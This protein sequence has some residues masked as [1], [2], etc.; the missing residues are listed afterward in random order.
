MKR[1]YRSQYLVTSDSDHNVYQ[2]AFLAVDKDKIIDAGLWKNRPR[3]KSYKTIDYSNAVITPGLFNLHSHLAMTFLKGIVEDVDLNTWLFDYILPA[4]KKLVSKKFVELGTQLALTECLK[5]GTTYIADMYFHPEQVFSAFSKLGLRGTVGVSFF[6]HGGMDTKSLDESFE[7]ILSMNQKFKQNKLLDLAIAPHAPYTCSKQNLRKGV[8]IAKELG[9]PGMIHVAETRFEYDEIMAKHNQSPLQYVYECG[10][11]D[12]PYLLLAHMLHLNEHEDYQILQNTR[13]T[14]ILTPQCNA[15]LASGTPLAQQYKDNAIRFTMG[16]DGSASNNS[17][18]IF[19]ELNF[20]AKLL[21]LQT[22][23]L[24]GI[25]SR[26]LFDSVTIRA[27]E[28]VG[29][30]NELGS[31]EAGKQADFIVIPLDKAHLF[32]VNDIYSQLLY[33]IRGHDVRDVYIQ[34]KAVLKN[35]KVRGLDEAQ[36][37]QKCQRYWK[38]A[39]KAL[40]SS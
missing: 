15:K 13:A 37:F 34:G 29:K 4:E 16:T 38:S 39:S 24:D 31:L 2:D 18:D 3:S 8:E 22:G 40:V 28:A 33:V 19:S 21:N 30:Q 12:L 5:N 7:L 1:L 9:L 25:S 27:A 23:R 20:L 36:L 32:P 14:P 35:G 17:L 6:D 26:D 11:F 10:L